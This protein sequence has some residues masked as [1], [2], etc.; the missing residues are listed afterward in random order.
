VVERLSRT[1]DF[2]ARS[3]TLLLAL[4]TPQALCAA[5]FLL[6]LLSLES[7]SQCLGMGAIGGLFATPLIT[8]KLW[9]YLRSREHVRMQ[10]KRDERARS[11]GNDASGTGSPRNYCLYLRPFTATGKVPICVLDCV[12]H[13][14]RP[15]GKPLPPHRDRTFL[16]FETV[17]A[18]ALDSY[19]PL[20]CLGLSGEQVGAGRIQ[21]SDTTWR[22]V[23]LRL[24]SAAHLILLIPS[25]RKGT[26]W[27]LKTILED[28]ALLSKTVFIIPPTV[29]DHETYSLALSSS[30]RSA[31]VDV[32][33]LANV[34]IAESGLA[35]RWDRQAGGVSSAP[36][37]FHVG[38]SPVRFMVDRGSRVRRLSSQAGDC[39]A[40][41]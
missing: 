11:L 9:T 31:G 25:V 38:P 4:L 20:I 39:K 34:N 35:F 17:L 18:M 1:P 3:S 6:F 29:G 23:F 15:N 26:A 33:K 36:L 41:F 30:E 22:K 8:K 19:A 24:A 10:R 12:T 32:R 21:T 13:G 40:I 5:S 27:E 7:S 28:S 14:R 16:D 37:I 2:S